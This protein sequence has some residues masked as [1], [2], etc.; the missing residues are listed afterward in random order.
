LFFFWFQD[1]HALNYAEEQSID[2]VPE[3]STS[4]SLS[5]S[6]PSLSSISD[7]YEADEDEFPPEEDSRR[8][9]DP[10]QHDVFQTSS[11]SSF[12]DNIPL[13]QQM[14]YH[15][16]GSQASNLDR[17]SVGNSYLTHQSQYQSSTQ[18]MVTESSKSSYRQT[19]NSF[20]HLPISNNQPYYLPSPS[21]SH[22]MFASSWS[23]HRHFSNNEIPDSLF[24]SIQ[25]ALISSDNDTG[26]MNQESTQSYQTH[27]PNHAMVTFNCM[28]TPLSNIAYNAQQQKKQP[29]RLLKYEEE[30]SGLKSFKT[31]LD[32][33]N[34]MGRMN[35][36]SNEGFVKNPISE[37]QVS[38]PSQSVS[39]SSSSS[40]TFNSTLETSLLNSF[41]SMSWGSDCQSIQ[42]S[43]KS[44]SP[45]SSHSL[46]PT[47]FV[48]IQLANSLISQ[49]LASS[50]PS[51]LLNDNSAAIKSQLSAQSST[52]L[53]SVIN[54]ISFHHL[55]ETDGKR[56]LRELGEASNEL[57]GWINN[58]GFKVDDE[59]GWLINSS[60]LNEALMALGRRG[61]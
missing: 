37:E 13:S 48:P 46:P 22:P 56:K 49:I 52:L 14:E 50:N 30:E 27:H 47:N 11:S 38:S 31:D 15:G 58:Q 6:R 5:R 54:L 41:S 23:P 20:S 16:S 57:K 8:T 51:I 53:F 26:K 7:G 12:V 2:T 59:G 44:G 19:L 24:N 25:Q 9:C 28:D 29:H 10:P 32:G 43:S 39:S 42:T 35:Q 60:M 40:S 61:R 18:P 4:K 21:P 45:S 17:G 3:T 1:H 55:D 36:L 33:I 34:G